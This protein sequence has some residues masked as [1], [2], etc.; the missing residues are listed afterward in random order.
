MV[1]P[2]H[3]LYPPREPV[4]LRAAATVILLRDGSAGMEVLMTRRSPHASFAAGAFVFPGGGLDRIDASAQ[5]HALA[6]VRPG[7]SDLRLTQAIT[8]V[9]ES[10]EELGVLLAYDASGRMLDAQQLA[11]LDRRACSASAS[12]FIGQCAALGWTLATDQLHMLAHW[13]T[14]RDLPKRFDVPFL[15]ARM[16]AAQLPCADEQEQFEPVW[17]TPAQALIRHERGQM[18]IIFPTLRTLEWLSQQPDVDSVLQR[19]QGASPQWM[20]CPRAGLLHGQEARFME[21]EQPYA[22]LALVCPDGQ[23]VHELA[24]QH[25]QA[26]ALLKNLRRLT[27]PNPGPM[28]GPGTNSYLI[29]SPA[30]GY[31]VID[32]GPAIDAHVQRLLAACCGDVRAILCS[33]SHPDHAPAAWLLQAACEAQGRPRP[34][35]LGLRSGR[36]ADSKSQFIPDRELHDGERIALLGDGISHTLRCV[37][38]P[39][40][41]ANHL[42]LLFEEEGLLFTGDHVLGGST[43]VIRPPDGSM[44][45]YLHSL[46]RLQAL[47]QQRQ[48]STLLPAHG[49]AIGPAVE[50]LAELRRHRLQREQKIAQVLE[51]Q[52]ELAFDEL[53]AQVYDDVAPALWPVA[54]GTLRAHLERLGKPIHSN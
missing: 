27:A 48:V 36:Y 44:T 52:P 47:C 12:A 2:A 37:H 7:Q 49:H 20:S 46:E 40:H 22:E 19:C 34:P 18:P 1:R 31:L 28:T 38:T 54:A 32:P 43:P 5:A 53:L 25:Q 50:A 42:C 8:A 13:I 33:H 26:V 21:H 4:A 3:L 11:R 51:R 14:S 17:L 45:D 41:A 39:G 29:G 9:R 23:L 6:T 30:A 10:Y 24:W 35:V 16:P 15:V